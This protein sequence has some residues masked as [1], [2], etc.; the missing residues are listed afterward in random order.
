MD[1]KRTVGCHRGERPPRRGSPR[2]L[3]EQRLLV[4]DVIHRHE[5]IDDLDV[6]V[7]VIHCCVHEERDHGR[8]RE[9]Q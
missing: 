3:F 7:L 8:G 4:P 1:R 5:R 6:F 2:R 9:L